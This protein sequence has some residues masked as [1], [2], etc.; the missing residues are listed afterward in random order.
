MKRKKK[1]FFAK[2]FSFGYRVIT[3]SSKKN[4][5]NSGPEIGLESVIL[6]TNFLWQTFPLKNVQFCNFLA[7]N[8]TK[9]NLWVRIFAHAIL[10]Y[11]NVGKQHFTS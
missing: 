6:F 10:Y 9:Q 5:V 1:I 7:K 11:T 4:I 8:L 3:I 2:R